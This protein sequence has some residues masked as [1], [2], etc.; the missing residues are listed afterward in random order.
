MTWL[1]NVKK[2]PNYL[3][4]KSFEKLSTTKGFVQNRLKSLNI[5]AVISLFNNLTQEEKEAALSRMKE[6]T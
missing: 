1:N 6:L 2:A 5:E 4:E 3:T